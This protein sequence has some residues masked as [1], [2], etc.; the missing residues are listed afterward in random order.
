MMIRL[1][2]KKIIKYISLVTMVLFVLSLSLILIFSAT[3]DVFNDVQGGQITEDGI[4]LPIIMYHS[5]LKNNHLGKY[6]ITPTEFENDLKYLKEH[7][8]STINMTDLINYVYNNGDIPLKPVIITFDDGNLNNY[9]YGQPILQKYNMKAV[10]SIIGSYTE[11]FSKEPYPTNDPLY[12]HVSWDQIRNISNSGYFEIQ[13]HSYYLHSL[14]RR[15][16]AKRKKGEPL[17][18]YRSALVN[19]IGKLQDKLTEVTGITPNTFTYPYGAIS[20]ESKDILKEMGFKASLSCL[21]GVNIINKAKA[22]TLFGLKRKNR[23]HGVSSAAFF[24]NFCP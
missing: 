7:N 14:N 13:N 8:Y 24:K 15:S 3:T 6:V 5:I 23:P 19:D 1:P 16:G 4:A 20:K 9:I 11:T 18:S 10:L 17:E 22:D 12:A 2:D 21:E